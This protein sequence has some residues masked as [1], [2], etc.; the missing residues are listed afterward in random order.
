MWS[1]CLPE[2]VLFHRARCDGSHHTCALRPQ[3]EGGEG[4]EG[5]W[6]GPIRHL[7]SALSESAK[8]W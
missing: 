8:R 7:S 4:G 2:V 3:R 6:F 5:G 1:K